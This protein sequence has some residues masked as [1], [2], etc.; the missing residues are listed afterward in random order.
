MSRLFF[1]PFAVPYS[2]TI[3]TSSLPKYSQ[4]NS[5]H[6]MDGVGALMEMFFLGVGEHIHA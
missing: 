1:F 2:I 3:L 4:I 5:L 6:D